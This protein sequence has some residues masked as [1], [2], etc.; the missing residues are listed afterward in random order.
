[1]KCLVWMLTALCALSAGAA[2]LP[3]VVPQRTGP[4]YDWSPPPTAA[5]TNSDLAS[6][7]HHLAT[8]A[9]A[10]IARISAPGTALPF[11]YSNGVWSQAF[12]QYKPFREQWSKTC[13]LYGVKGLSATCL[14]YTNGYGGAYPITMVSPRHYV[15]SWHIAGWFPFCA[16]KD[17]A[18][19]L[20]TKNKLY[21]R[22]SIQCLNAGNDIAVGLLDADLPPSVGF[23]PVLPANYTNYVGASDWV[24]GVGANCDLLVFSQPL[25]LDPVGVIWNSE[26]QINGGLA[27]NWN[28]RLRNGDS[29]FPQ[30][31]L[32]GNQLVLVS[33]A[34][35]VM[36]GANYAQL[37]GRIN[38]A[39]HQ[40]SVTNHLSTDYQLTTVDLS[41]FARRK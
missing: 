1:M 12:Y 3:K 34:T 6:L 16:G 19:F 40:L 9:L 35:T 33:C 11:L 13:W 18:V 25:R 26:G 17:A 14:G 38:A 27:T 37:A 30:R 15:A 5:V 22:R 8:N 21:Q 31:L 39:M 41:G 10:R 28:H 7:A 32:I 2:D 20:D 29:S 36:G 24:Q 23:L 4:T